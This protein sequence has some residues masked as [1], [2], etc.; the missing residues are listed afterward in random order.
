[1]D[2]VILFDGASGVNLAARRRHCGYVA[3]NWA[4]FLT[5]ERCRR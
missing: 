3:R 2:D 5:H 4:L 1:M